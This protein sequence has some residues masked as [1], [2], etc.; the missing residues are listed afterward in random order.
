M[1]LTTKQIT[2]LKNDFLE[3]GWNTNKIWKE[4]P[5]FNCSRIA[6]TI[7]SKK[8]RRLGQVNTGKEVVSQLVLQHNKLL[9]TVSCWFVHNKKVL[10]PSF[11]CEK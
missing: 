3:K 6:V 1:A 8:L 10:G 7:L 11:Q 5:T 2:V 4:H 9:M